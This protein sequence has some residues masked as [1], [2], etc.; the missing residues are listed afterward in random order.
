[1]HFLL[2]VT[3]IITQQDYLQSTN[4]PFYIGHGLPSTL[5]GFNVS[6][7]LTPTGVR[8]LDLLSTLEGCQ[9]VTGQLDGQQDLI[10]PGWWHTPYMQVFQNLTGNGGQPIAGPILVLQGT[11][12]NAVPEPVTSIAVNETCAAYPDSQLEYAMFEGATHV[13][14]LYASQRVWLDWI[15][16]RFAARASAAPCSRQLYRPARPVDDYQVELET[17][18]ELATQSYEVA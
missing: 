5:P 11:S 7:F 10:K 1:M 16:D 4:L 18:L 8:H 12:D 3:N 2:A 14:V 17:Y 13:P 6:D 15:E 9:S